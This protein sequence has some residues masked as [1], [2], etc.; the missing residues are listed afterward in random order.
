MRACLL[1]LLVVLLT[2]NGTAGS[3]K[4]VSSWMT[5]NSSAYC[6]CAKCCGRFSDGVTHNG[7]NAW[8]AGV[9]VDPAVIPIGSRLDIPGYKRGANG[10]GSWILADDTGSGI[11]GKMIDIRFKTHSEALKWG[12][13]DIRI[14]VWRR[15]Q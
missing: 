7:K 6:P 12:R 1:I 3:V 4:W 8:K 15:Q 9:A 10:N 2:P 5:V 14:R 11:E 13:K